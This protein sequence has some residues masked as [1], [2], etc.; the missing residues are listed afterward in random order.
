MFS[1]RNPTDTSSVEMHRMSDPI[2][3]RC[4]TT[5]ACPLS[6][7]KGS[8]PKCC[9]K[10][11]FCGT[12][13]FHCASRWG[14]QRDCDDSIDVKVQPKNDDPMSVLRDSDP[15]KQIILPAIS[16]AAPLCKDKCS[17][18]LSSSHVASNSAF[19][20]NVKRVGR[21]LAKLLKRA[22]RN[23]AALAFPASLRKYRGFRQG[24]HQHESPPTFPGLHAIP[25]DLPFHAISR[26]GFIHLNF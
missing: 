14:C 26:Y 12:R 8:R 9:S 20:L 17:S 19:P 16:L 4:S 15:E 24:N 2:F 11:G 23:S 3:V 18:T 22:S 5:Q 1:Q 10:W 25:R 13:V 7:G 6:G 21:K